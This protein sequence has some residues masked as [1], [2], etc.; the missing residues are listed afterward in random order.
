MTI[1]LNTIEEKLVSLTTLANYSENLVINLNKRGASVV[2]GGI[3]TAKNSDQITFHIQVNH[4]APETR[5][6]VL[7][8]TVLEDKAV[9]NLT[10]LVKIQ[11]GAKNS[12][13]FLKEDALILSP[14]AQAFAIPSLEIEENEVKA[15]H[16]S[17]VGPVDQDQIFYLQS[18]GINLKQAEKMVV[19]GFLQPVKDK[20]NSY[21]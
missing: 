13:S 3:L 12:H 21:G 17:F 9:V 2:V 10:G 14:D 7:I 11:K 16:S 18:R 20:L 5:S 19:S 6:D 4:N 15:G 8:R 1:D